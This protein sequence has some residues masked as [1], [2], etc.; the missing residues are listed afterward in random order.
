[1]RDQWPSATCA[2]QHQ[3]HRQ[4]KIIKM[5]MDPAFSAAARSNCGAQSASVTPCAAT[6]YDPGTKM[7]IIVGK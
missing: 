5:T 3:K 7:F 6:R 1:M 2:Q 4:G